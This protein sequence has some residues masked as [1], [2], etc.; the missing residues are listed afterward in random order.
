MKQ[1]K[2]GRYVFLSVLGAVLFIVGLVLLLLLP[3]AEGILKTLPFVCVG[4][5]AGIFGGN[6]SSAM[7]N[8]AINKNPQLAK[9][10]EIEAK[11]ERNY[12][13]RNKAKA[14]AYN[15]MIFVYAAILLAFTLMQVEAYII[16]TLVGAYLFFIFSYVYYLS[17]YYKEM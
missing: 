14:S 15:L 4:V 7:R 10:A 17:K 3:D 12:M 11:D 16:L 13:I 8:R 1:Y 6:F 2:V 5:G 9:Q